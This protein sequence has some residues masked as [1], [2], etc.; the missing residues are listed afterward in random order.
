MIYRAFRR[1]LFVLAVALLGTSCALPPAAVPDAQGDTSEFRAFLD[2][3][4]QEDLALSPVFASRTGVKDYQDRWSR[5]DEAFKQ[6]TR[7]RNERLLTELAQFDRASLGR[8]EQLSYDLYQ[9]RLQRRLASD[10]YRHH[11]FVIH[12]HRGPHTRVP[13]H[14]INIHQITDV[15]DAEAYIARLHKVGDYFDGVIEQ[16][17]IRSEKGY[18]LADWQYPR[19]IQSARNV[20][21]GAPFDA[22][23]VDSTLWADFQSK[24]AALDLEG[25]QRS[26]LVEGARVALLESF[27]PAY[28]R[29]IDALE[30]QSV[31]AP[32]ADGVWKFPRGDDFY[33]ERLR[34]YTTTELTANEVH[35]IGLRE[36]TRIHAQMRGVM[37]ELGFSGDLSDF[38]NFMRNDPQFYYPST[39]AGREAYL[40]EARAIIDEMYASLPEVFGLLPK[41]A[42][43]VKQV[44]AFRERSSGKAFYQ[45]PPPDGSRPGIYYANLYNMASMPKYQMAALAFHEGV[46]GHH[47]QRA[48]SV[49][50]K[51]I[52]EFQKYTSFTAY[53]EGWGLYSESLAG[54]MGFYRDPYSDFGR[55]S[56]ELWRAC[57]LVVDTG[58]HSKRWS[59]EEAIDYLL[60]NTPNAKADAT[61]STE[62]YIAQPGQATAYMVGKLKLMEL[63]ERAREAMGDTFDLREFHD[64]VLEDGPVPLSML[65]AKINAMINPS[66]VPTGR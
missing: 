34:W 45:A 33:A 7:Q 43:T 59:R 53:T 9:L 41:A 23:G 15:A 21:R 4:W 24:V 58:I 48:I 11:K 57:R 2:A 1:E 17:Q 52:P 8:A 31:D 63:R 20:I 51:G 14:L 6:Q 3:T 18:L 62:R 46:P 38:F 10:E 28:A 32:D 42:I 54:E 64:A 44:E 25:A 39:D 61:K 29:L 22:S 19:M 60:E 30:E 50:L 27:A 26:S 65:E 12:Q 5:V 55:L 37:R 35:A 36:V 40:S 13:S 16:L 66:H 47:M 56:T 49:E